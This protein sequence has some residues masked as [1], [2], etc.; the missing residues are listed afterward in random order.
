M[1]ALN[2]L[3]I[4][5]I[6]RLFNFFLEVHMMDELAYVWVKECNL[7]TWT[8]FRLEYCAMWQKKNIL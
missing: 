5:Y 3:L 2:I 1:V 6:L 4:K 7:E 8:H